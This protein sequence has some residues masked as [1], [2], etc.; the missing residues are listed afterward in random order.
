MSVKRSHS[1]SRVLAVLEAIAGHQPVGVRALARVLDADKSAIQ[2]ALMTLADEG[3]IRTT[4]EPP[5]RWELS[6]R[7]LAVAHAAQGSSDLR[8]RARPLLERLRD[9]TGETALLVVPD[10]QNFVIADVV[11][12]RQILRMVPQVGTRVAALDTATGRAVLPFMDAA[13]QLSLL[14]AAPDARSQALFEKTRVQGYAVSDGEINLAA[15][16]IAAPV[17]DFDGSAAGA[18][19]VTGPRER[20]TTARHEAIGKSVQRAAQE[21]SRSNN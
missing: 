16:N 14:G 18:V 8:R 4:S 5:V 21:L 20:L 10:L 6:P 2:R 11:E 9:D 1:G 3:W 12:S 7:I 19:V 15:A 17:F 13:R